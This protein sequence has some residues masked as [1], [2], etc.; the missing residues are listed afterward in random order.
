MLEYCKTN[1]SKNLILKLIVNYPGIRYNDLARITKLNNGVLSYSL[2]VLE[3]NDLIK[4]S[5]CSNGR[6]T[7][8]FSASVSN[9]DFQV[10]GYLKNSTPNKIILLLHN[11]KESTTFDE[12]KYHI[13]KSSSTTSWNLKRLL[14]DNIITRSKSRKKN[15]FYSLKDPGLIDRLTRN[16]S[17]LYLDKALANYISFIE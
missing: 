2:H 17:N 12:I 3:K 11:N 5:R 1:G 13:K 9:D 10:I 15:Y 8:Y 7:R 16:P 4:V 6:T 14:N